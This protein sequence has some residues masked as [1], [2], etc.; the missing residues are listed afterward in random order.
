MELESGMPMFCKKKVVRWIHKLWQNKPNPLEPD[1]LL[2]INILE[3]TGNMLDQI[4]SEFVGLDLK[5]SYGV[6]I[7]R[8][9]ASG[10]TDVQIL[11]FVTPDQNRGR[12]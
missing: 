5:Y 4:L 11:Q 8:R 3:Q 12:V 10:F 2:E 6:H 1:E 7:K 9:V